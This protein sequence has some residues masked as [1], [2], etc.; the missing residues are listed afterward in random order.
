MNSLWSKRNNT[1]APSTLFTLQLSPRQVANKA[2]SLGCKKLDRD[3]KRSKQR[4]HVRE[5]LL[6]CNTIA[7]AED[8]LNSRTRRLN[9]RVMSAEDDEEDSSDEFTMKHQEHHHEHHSPLASKQQ[10]EEEEDEEEGTEMNPSSS[11][12]S[13][14]CTLLPPCRITIN[15][16]SKMMPIAAII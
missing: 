8:V 7:K 4:Y 5:R 15:Q 2:Y 11:S 13:L 16:T 14:D 10:E 12:S 9:R 6:L 1:A 3:G